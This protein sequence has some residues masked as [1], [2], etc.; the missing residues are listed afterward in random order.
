M[1]EPKGPNNPLRARNAAVAT[2]IAAHEDE[3]HDYMEKE[4]EARGL[5][6]SRPLTPEQ[7]AANDIA[8]ILDK[9]PHLAVQFG[10]AQDAV[11][12]IKVAG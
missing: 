9:Y 6:Y 12:A 8:A 4:H 5:T 2:L 1:A 3:F 10:A 11:A 7:K